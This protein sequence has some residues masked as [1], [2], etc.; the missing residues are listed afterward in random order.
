MI[1]TNERPTLLKV[2]G[3][4]IVDVVEEFVSAGRIQELRAFI[5]TNGLVARLDVQAVANLKAFLRSEVSRSGGE[6]LVAAKRAESSAQPCSPD[7]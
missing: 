4:L 2:S 3:L 6:A 5:E 7:P 1:D